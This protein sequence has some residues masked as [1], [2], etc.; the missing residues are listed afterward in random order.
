R[1]YAMDG[2]N[3]PLGGLKSVEA[4]GPT[5][6]LAPASGIAGSGTVLTGTNFAASASVSVYWGTVATGTLLATGATDA[7]GALTAGVNVT[8]PAASPGAYA[9]TAVD[10]RSQYA[11]NTSYTVLAP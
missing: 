4:Y 6:A 5:I 10:N 2:V 3:N 11:V 1:I 9:V 7:S 8:V